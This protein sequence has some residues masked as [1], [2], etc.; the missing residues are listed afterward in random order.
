[1]PKLRRLALIRFQ[2]SLKDLPGSDGWVEA[3][4]EILKQATAYVYN[5]HSSSGHGIRQALVERLVKYAEFEG[6]SKQFNDLLANAQ[7][8]GADLLIR[9]AA[10]HQTNPTTELMQKWLCPM[11]I[12]NFWCDE[13]IRPVEYCPHCRSRK[14]S[15]V[16]VIDV[17]TLSRK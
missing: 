15:F 17:A 11:C 4:G 7:P 13:A 6:A 14:L 9:E 8:L 16:G 10:N 12:G 5:D 3:D 1:M 2:S